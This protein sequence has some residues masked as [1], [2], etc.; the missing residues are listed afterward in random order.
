MTTI[1]EW[2]AAER[3]RHAAAIRFMQAADQIRVLNQLADQAGITE[4]VI[5]L[6]VLIAAR[7]AE[8]ECVRLRVWPLRRMHTMSYP[9][10]FRETGDLA[11]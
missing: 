2:A 5:P 9:K 11:A 10:R 1:A 8:Y 6:I 7:D 4:E 3:A